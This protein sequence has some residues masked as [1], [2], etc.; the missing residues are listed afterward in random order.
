MSRPSCPR[1]ARTLPYAALRCTQCGWTRGEPAGDLAAVRRRRGRAT[2]VGLVLLGLLGVGAAWRNSE[3]L[4]GWYAAF[5]ARYLPASASSFGPA[6]SENGAY[7]FCARRVAKQIGGEFSV[8]TFPDG[9][10]KHTAAVAPGL[11]EIRSFVDEDRENGQR[12][13]HDFS[14]RVRYERGRW[15][16]ERLTVGSLADA[17]AGLVGPASR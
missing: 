5:A 17:A 16:L 9:V 8:E 15:V 13:R 4:A 11:Y 1:C 6:D 14:C 2:L 7:Y 3:A 10:E 12:V